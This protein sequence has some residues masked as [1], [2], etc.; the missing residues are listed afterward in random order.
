MKIFTRIF[1]LVALLMLSISVITTSAQDDY[2][3]NPDGCVTG[4]EA[5]SF[6]ALGSSSLPT[7]G[8]W[9]TF[10][11]YNSGALNAPTFANESYSFSS[12][13]S[14]QISIT[15]Y[16]AKGDV[17]NIYD[18]GGLIG[19]TSPAP[20]NDYTSCYIIDDCF[21]DPDYSSGVFVLPAGS[22]T[23]TFETIQYCTAD[24]NCRG[25]NGAIKADVNIT[26]NSGD[27]LIDFIEGMGLP[28]GVENS[29]TGVLGQVTARLSDGN[30]NNDGAACDKLTDFM[31]HVQDRLDQGKLTAEQAGMLTDYAQMIK[32]FAGC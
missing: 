22:H 12:A 13:F 18:N 29:L 11:W 23:L 6:A 30:P 17:F 16:Q 8:Q 25:G 27:E 7:D 2:C 19:T 31:A 10:Y 3:Q 26:A 9:Y 32:D 20:F 24:G 28:N 5:S 15:D 4:F 21:A 14:V 1:I